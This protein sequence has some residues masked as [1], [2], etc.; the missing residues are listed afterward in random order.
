MDLSLLLAFTVFLATK[1]KKSLTGQNIM[2][3]VTSS[4]LFSVPK[5][6]VALSEEKFCPETVP[7][8]GAQKDKLQI[9]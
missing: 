1:L 7:L 5:L 9:N 8:Q 6:C 2:T 3:L 4:P